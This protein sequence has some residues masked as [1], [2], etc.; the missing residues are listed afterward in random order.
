MPR[1]KT[2][3]RYAQ[4]S[5]SKQEAAV[6]QQLMQTPDVPPVQLPQATTTLSTPQDNQPVES[7]GKA[8]CMASGQFVLMADKAGAHLVSL[9]K[10]EWLRVYGQ[11][12]VGEQGLKTQP[13]LVP[14]SLKIDAPQAAALE[15]NQPLLSQLGIEIKFR[16]QQTVMVM[17]VPAPLRQQN[18]Q[19]LIPDLLSYA[20]LNAEQ[21]QLSANL[22]IGTL[23]KW[24]A[25]QVVR[26]KNDYTLSE[27]IQIVAE[28][29]MLWQGTLPLHDT[30]F[31][32]PIDFS[33]TIAAFNL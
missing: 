19:Q 10:A 24:L 8:I 26:V 12:Q 4:P 5:P 14:L 31:V 33:A 30:Q 25:D 22:S 3:D 15:H 17:G 32:R 11:L 2:N 13:L 28:V 29:E 23:S 1:S 7:L 9:A 20:A 6:Y 18:L 16:N 21:S 27:A